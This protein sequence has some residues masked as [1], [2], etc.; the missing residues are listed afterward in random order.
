MIDEMKCPNCWTQVRIDGKDGTPPAY[1]GHDCP[2][3][4]TP[5]DYLVICQPQIYGGANVC[6]TF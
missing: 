4:F 3:N 2:A 1:V 5:L 6:K